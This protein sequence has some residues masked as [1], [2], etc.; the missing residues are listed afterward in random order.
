MG[1]V[2]AIAGALGACVSAK[3]PAGYSRIGSDINVET[4]QPHEAAQIVQEF[5]AKYGA[6]PPSEVTQEVASMAEVRDIIRADRLTDYETA[7]RFTAGKHGAEAL[8]VRAYL[9]L[10]QGSAMLTTAAILE[11]RRTQAM[12]E[13]RQLTGPSAYRGASEEASKG[14][15]SRTERL[16]MRTEDLRKVV[17]ALQLLAHEPISMGADFA[18]QAV[19]H[20]PKNQRAH[21]ARA[22]AFRLQGEWLEFDR[23]MRHANDLGE[24]PPMGTY[25]RAMEALERYADFAKCRELLRQMLRREPEF[26]R[27]QANLVLASKDVARRHEEL[28]R[29][30]EQSAEHI[31]VRLAGPMIERE[32]QTVK[33]LAHARGDGER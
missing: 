29:L 4:L 14:D 13:L 12:T 7:R 3:T 24:N 30:K 31:V 21:L 16:R 6:E 28:Q 5:S 9:E 32:Y 10:S 1:L 17:H 18:K 25:L 15:A 27:A 11:E 19:R 22:D 2:V 8:T 20:D 33:E 26:V 23:M